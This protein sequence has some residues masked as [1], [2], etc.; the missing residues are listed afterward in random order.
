M[1]ANLSV[2]HFG[3]AASL[4]NAFVLVG[5]DISLRDKLH[6]QWHG[7]YLGLKMLVLITA[8]GGITYLFNQGA[9][10]ICLASIIAFTSALAVDTAIYGTLIKRQRIIKMNLS[11][12]GSAAVDSTLFPTIA[13]G[14]F[15]PWIVLL[16]FGA[17]VLGGFAWSIM[18]NKIDNQSL[19]LTAKSSGK[20]V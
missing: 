15:M 4:F 9:G 10:R 3:P 8:G 5:L 18:L 2:A 16:M 20:S 11:N 14:V 13:F 1:L 6:E 17:K 12:I 19:D 7:R